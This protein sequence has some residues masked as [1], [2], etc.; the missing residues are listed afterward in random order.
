[1]S[2]SHHPGPTL[3][4]P[5]RNA[6]DAVRL[7]LLAVTHPLEA[8]TLCFL[9]DDDGNGV[10][11][12]IT[13]VSGTTNP[14]ALLDVVELIGRVGSGVPDA[15]ALVVATVRPSHGVL[16]GDVDLW[17]EASDLAS[18]HGIELREWFII[19]PTGAICPRDLLGEPERWPRPL[20]GDQ[21]DQ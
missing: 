14:E 18:A 12:V 16:P 20:P 21:G 15:T 2:S 19:S 13:V 6:A 4:T 10:A 8:E 3:P 9:L 1:M 7:L 17:L 5:V 11:G